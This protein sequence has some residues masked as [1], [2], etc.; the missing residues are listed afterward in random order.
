MKPYV[1]DDRDKFMRGVDKTE[2]MILP[3][4]RTDED[5]A[6]PFSGWKDRLFFF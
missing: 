6:E 4:C 3:Y 5:A 2:E 1:I